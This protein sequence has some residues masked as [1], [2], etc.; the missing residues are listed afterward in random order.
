[1]DVVIKWPGSLHDAHIVANSKIYTFFKSGKI[2]GLEKW[3]VDNEE[4]IPIFLLGDPAY[5]LLQYL[6]KEYSNGGSTLRNNTKIIL[7]LCRAHIVFK[8]GFKV[9]LRSGLHP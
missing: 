2:P 9:N 6:M 8:C 4:P 3:I 5:P 1:M 7:S